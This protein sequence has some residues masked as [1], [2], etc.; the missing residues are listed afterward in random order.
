MNIYQIAKLAEVSPATVSKVINGRPGVG[1]AVRQKVLDTIEAHNFVPK[2]SV[3]IQNNVAVIFRANDTTAGIFYSDYMIGIM[4]GLCEYV[5]DHNYNVVL[6]PS[7]VLPKNRSQFAMFCK[8]QRIVGC[9]FG[10]LT[11]DDHYIEDIAGIVPIVMFNAQ[12]QGDMLYSICSDDY[13][14]MYRTI[15]Y[16]RNMGHRRIAIGSVGLW[17][18]SNFNKLKA[19]HQAV[20]DFGLV[21]DQDY[22]IDFDYYDSFSI[23]ALV[24]RL[25]NSGRLPTAFLTMNDEE[26]VRLITTLKFMGLRCPEDISVVGYDDYPYS[27]HTQP[28]LTTVKQALYEMGKAA[29]KLVCGFSPE[30]MGVKQDKQGSFIFETQLVERDSVFNRNA[31]EA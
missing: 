30:N 22:I 1:N 18:L 14:G 27:S 13:G 29:G 6:F 7:V 23:C 15:Q 3:S 21:E 4:R 10:N 9:A 28:A 26:A 25:R 8:M 2:T 12:Y 5:F 11:R 20:R 17:Y 19:Y 16:L 24:E 31:S